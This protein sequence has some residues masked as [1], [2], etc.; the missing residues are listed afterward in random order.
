[1]VFNFL[2]VLFSFS[3]IARADVCPTLLEQE[4][5]LSWRLPVDERLLEHPR[6]QRGFVEV[7][8]DWD[9]AENSLKLKVFYRLMPTKTGS[10]DDASKPIVV[11]MN[12]GPGVASNRSRSLDYDYVDQPEKGDRFRHLS[13]YFRILLVDQRGS[14][15]LTHPLN[16]E[17]E[18]IDQH[19]VGKFAQSRYLAL[20]HAAVINH[21]I[22][23]N[24]KFFAIAQSY[25]GL[26]GSQY[27]V[28]AARNPNFVQTPAGI[29]F[30]SSALPHQDVEVFGD[31]RRQSQYELNL[32]LIQAY[33]DIAFRIMLVR[34]RVE[35]VMPGSTFVDYHYSILGK[36]EDWKKTLSDKMDKYI[37]ASDDELRDL[38]KNGED[39]PPTLLNYI[40][41]PATFQQG[42]TDRYMSEAQMKTL[43]FPDWMLDEC[44]HYCNFRAESP[45]VQNLLNRV[46]QDPPKG[47]DYHSIEEYRAAFSRTD[48]IFTGA[49]DDPMVP[50]SLSRIMIERLAP[51]SA[52]IVELNFGHSAITEEPGVLMLVKHWLQK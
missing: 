19:I 2:V 11:F 4:K 15:G 17:D 38:I 45:L 28:E 43:P 49:N 12:G 20:D 44:R 31:A 37:L 22:G 51:P 25:G 34:K 48:V 41:S 21:V 47:E 36:G 50:L 6:E 23:P 40:L 9:H 27:M 24:Q 14:E 7:P 13:K 30:S 46:D 8:V 26:V 52:K 18:S 3:F 5:F 1:M 33:P 29:V 32:Q 35:Q 42:R 39:H 16:L 10:V